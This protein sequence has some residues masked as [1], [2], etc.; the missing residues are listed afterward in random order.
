MPDLEQREV[1]V[2]GTSAE[3]Y[4]EI[5]YDKGTTDPGRVFRAMA[6]AIAGIEAMDDALVSAI[7]GKIGSQL[8]LD[9]IEVSSI[10]AKLSTFL[11]S[12]D[13]EG[14]KDLDWKKIVGGFLNQGRKKTIELLDAGEQ[15][16]V[17][18]VEVLE[19]EIKELAESTDV[20]Q[21]PTYAVPQ[22]RALLESVQKVERSLS[23]LGPTDKAY[24][25]DIGGDG[26]AVSKT[27][28]PVR[29]EG[30]IT[31]QQIEDMLAE[32]EEFNEMTI[33]LKVKK[34]DYLGHSMWALRHGKRSIE[35]QMA[36]EQWLSDFHERRV[37]LRPGD[38]IK[39]RVEYHTRYDARHEVV[40][41]RYRVVEV[42]DIH[43]MPPTPPQL[44]LGV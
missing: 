17:E 42:L 3:F 18:A 19:A 40:A 21:I 37:S 24:Y 33:I 30:L 13:E 35:A 8:V 32:T 5:D 27:P 31:A 39:A 10:R 23:E 34:P 4:V 6:G 14:L 43:P 44:A 16:T 15:V 9:D 36:D 38:S 29:S 7:S 2:Y 22:R 28:I 12:I 11:K 25:V 41:E 1:V 26:E 20:L